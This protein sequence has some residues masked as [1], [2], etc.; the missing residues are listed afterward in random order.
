MGNSH[1]I[2]IHIQDSSGSIRRVG[3]IRNFDA[4]FYENIK[5]RTERFKIEG[6]IPVKLEWVYNQ[7]KS[8]LLEKASDLE[9]LKPYDFKPE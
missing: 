2:I 6:I 9:K 3:T 7:V 1:R 8:I 5:L 4:I